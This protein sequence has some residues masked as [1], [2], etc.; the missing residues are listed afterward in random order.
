MRSDS[1]CHFFSQ[2]VSSGRGAVS[3]LISQP[4]AWCRSPLGYS[5]AAHLSREVWSRSRLSSGRRKTQKVRR[6]RSLDSVL[7]VPSPVFVGIFSG[8]TRAIRPCPEIT[9][10]HRTWQVAC[11]Y[12]TSF[13]TCFSL[14]MTT[15]LNHRHR[16]P[17]ADSCEAPSPSTAEI[18]HRK[19][20]TKLTNEGK[21]E[22][23][24]DYFICHPL[25]LATSA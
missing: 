3:S 19:A 16:Q 4:D 11:H 10:Q 20:C 15:Q 23:A 12:N 21:G 5:H 9:Q 2:V 18:L 25:T 13:C 22:R 7:P 6:S 17:L 24:G 1:R 8:G 14:L